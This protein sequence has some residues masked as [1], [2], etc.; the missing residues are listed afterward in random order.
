VTKSE[1]IALT[2]T[3]GDQYNPNSQTTPVNIKVTFTQEPA[4]IKA[5][6][7]SIVN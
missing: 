5:D 1:S 6:S 4:I 3:Y 7:T 2:I